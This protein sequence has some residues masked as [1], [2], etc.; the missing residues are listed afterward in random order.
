MPGSRNLSDV[1][2]SPE[3][4]PGNYSADLYDDPFEHG[5]QGSNNWIISGS[6][7]SN[8]HTLLANDP[9]RKIAIPSLRYIVHLSAPGW[10]VMGGGEPEIPGVAIGHN[11]AGAWGITISETDG[12]DLYVYNL[13]PA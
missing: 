11:E 7:T 12:E 2:N 13:N 6:R 1:R 9:H 3:P 8:G 5:I 4:T 10:N